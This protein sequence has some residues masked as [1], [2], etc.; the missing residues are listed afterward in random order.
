MWCALPKLIPPAG[1]SDRSAKFGLGARIRP[2]D[3]QGA[4]T[5]FMYAMDSRTRRMCISANATC[6][7]RR[8]TRS[9]DTALVRFHVRSPIGLCPA[10]RHH[11][12]ED[13]DR[14]GSQQAPV[15]VSQAN[16]SGSSTRRRP[17]PRCLK[18]VPRRLVGTHDEPP[19]RRSSSVGAAPVEPIGRPGLITCG[20]RKGAAVG[21]RRP[22]GAR[23]QPR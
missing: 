21:Q 8:T 12:T 5:G 17:T 22:G 20:A 16:V 15:F 4:T 6:C 11:E 14:V 23:V 19:V 3:A 7:P 10:V 2:G 18:A 9:T 13:A 1:W